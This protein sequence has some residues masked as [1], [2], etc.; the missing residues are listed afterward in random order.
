MNDDA[1]CEYDLL[2]R[3]GGVI[4]Q[5]DAAFNAVQACKQ[6]RCRVWPNAGK[7]VSIT[8]HHPGRESGDFL[9]GDLVAH[10]MYRV[11]GGNPLG[12]FPPAC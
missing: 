6:R 5:C 8:R 10:G 12:M 9:L 1:Q 7:Q 3:K 4:F 11:A 2:G